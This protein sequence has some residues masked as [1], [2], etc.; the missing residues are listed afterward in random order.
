MKK[1]DKWAEKEREDRGE[2]KGKERGEREER[3]EGERERGNNGL[4]LKFQDVD[5]VSKTEKERK[6]RKIEVYTY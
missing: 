2:R 1:R 4:E 3:G 6:N 5:S